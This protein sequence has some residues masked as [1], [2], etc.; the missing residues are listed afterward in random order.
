MVTLYHFV[1]QMLNW[2]GIFACNQMDVDLNPVAMKVIVEPLTR[3]L[4]VS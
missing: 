4:D 2:I 3:S 1:N